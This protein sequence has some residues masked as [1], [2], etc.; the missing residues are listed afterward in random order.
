MTFFLQEPERIP[1]T[2]ANAPQ[3][4]VT[5]FA[6]GLG[7]AFSRAAIENNANFRL[8]RERTAVRDDL[9][10]SVADRIGLAG[11]IDYVNREGP[12]FDHIRTAPTSVEDLF[13]QYGNEAT[14]WII[15]AAREQADRDPNAWN[16]VNLSDDAIEEQVNQRLA[17]EYER[18]VQEIDL[19]PAGQGTA[20]LLGSMAGISLDIKN[21]P[22]MLMGGG[23]GILRTAAR[24]AA[25]NVAAEAAFLPDQFRVAE[26][27]NIPDPSVGSQLAMAAA[28]GGAFGGAQAALGRGLRYVKQR[29]QVRAVTDFLND[30][31]SAQALDAV[32]RA[33]ETPNANPIAAASRALDDVLPDRAPPTEADLNMMPAEQQAA[34]DAEAWRMEAEQA[35]ERDF[36]EFA[37]R[38]FPLAELIKRKG[39]IAWYRINKATGER[40]LTKAAQELSAMGVTP[41]TH[42]YPGLWRK[43][44][45]TNLDNFPAREMDGLDQVL[46]VAGDGLYMDPD[47][48]IRAIGDELS[49]GRK[50]PLNGEIAAR[51]AELEQGPAQPDMPGGPRVFEDGF[52]ID[53]ADYRARFG[54]QADAQITDDVNAWLRQNGLDQF[55]TGQE[56]DDMVT[57]M[58]EQG[59]YLDDFIDRRMDD[60]LDR[61][62]ALDRLKEA[63][64]AEVPIQDPVPV[65]SD[66]GGG[67]SAMGPGGQ[68][69]PRPI[70]PD[71]GP[72]GRGS[73]AGDA[74]GA[75][76]ESTAAGQ[77]AVIPGVEPVTPRQRLEAAQGAPM[78][79]G[80]APADMGLFDVSGRSQR[81]LFSD[82]ASPEA[83]AVHDTIT[84]DLRQKIE[85]E[86]DFEIDMGDGRGVQKASAILDDIDR[87]QEWAETIDLC[88]RAQ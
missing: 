29:Q 11:I 39:G 54:D 64:N 40:E 41:Q 84:S 14:N 32:E 88:G 3:M 42:K 59:G 43:T 31:E 71:G 27:L 69:A 49:T 77:Q 57:A 12:G 78:R 76:Y 66:V 26:R 53:P 28:F 52:A 65:R 79:G 75:V 35:L 22:F 30:L 17:D 15:G 33:L 51:V 38:K 70:S 19:M 55:V 68:D 24:E 16:D 37:N 44:G 50:T 86:G 1:E 82:P 20:N 56:F 85:A 87:A 83:K 6:G 4:D 47:A 36:P 13:N 60:I 63:D 45:S 5:G 72:A 10:M 7:A 46:P 81:D 80:D 58:R 61:R 74:Q 62:D 8:G 2:K 73:R 21:L 18:L 23:G 34:V 9:A 48:L 25:I 67:Q